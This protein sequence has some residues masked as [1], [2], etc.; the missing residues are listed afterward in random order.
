MGNETII[1]GPESSATVDTCA[2]ARC[3]EDGPAWDA[4]S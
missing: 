3:V 1:L 2:W 4:S